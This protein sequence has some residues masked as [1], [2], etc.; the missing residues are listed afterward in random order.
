MFGGRAKAYVGVGMPKGRGLRK[1]GS[2][3]GELRDLGEGVGASGDIGLQMPFKEKSYM[4][5]SKAA[6][7]LAGVAL[8]TLSEAGGGIMAPSSSSSTGAWMCL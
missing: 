5:G 6:A 8:K 7:S 2:D 3:L 4:R 1:S